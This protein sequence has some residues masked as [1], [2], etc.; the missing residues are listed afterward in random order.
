MS[1]AST[2][3]RLVRRGLVHGATV[4]ENHHRRHRPVKLLWERA[5]ASSADFIEAHL[6]SAVVFD[7]REQL[8]EHAL[9]IM[10][11]TGM[12][13][14][15][16]VFEGQSINFIADWLRKR[17]DTRMAHGF[18]SFEG[19]EE[20]WSGEALPAGYF[21]QKG[22]LPAVRAGVRLH[23]GWIENTLPP[24]LAEHSEDPVALI[25]L[26]TDTY[27]PAKCVL[28][29][30]KPRLRPGSIIIFD[31][32]I[33]YPNWQAHEYRALVEVLGKTGYEFL[34]FTSRQSAL[35]I[36]EGARA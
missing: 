32:L 8:W 12:I 20:D 4:L 9:K 27:S 3:K 21:D 23:K 10:P 35:I 28:A 34:S 2:M 26:D 18:D 7:Q 29:N 25:H 17:G 22:K 19:L 14:E 33:G 1:V 36:T 13:L 15:F 5:A 30:L 6:S 16:G 11:Q 31:E 24:F